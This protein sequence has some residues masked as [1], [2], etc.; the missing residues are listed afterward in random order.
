[1]DKYTGTKHRTRTLHC[2]TGHQPPL[3][4]RLLYLPRTHYYFL[5][6]LAPVCLILQ[7]TLDLHKSAKPRNHLSVPV[8]ARVKP[9][10]P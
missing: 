2:S 6:S 1:M 10:P 8:R 5:R 7:R 4:N 9:V 3:R